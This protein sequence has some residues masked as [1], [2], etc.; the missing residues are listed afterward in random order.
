MIIRILGTNGSGKS[1]V[2]KLVTNELQH[3]Y[4]IKYPEENKR[5]AMGNIWEMKT[6]RRLF[7]P[8]HYNPGVNGGMDTIKILDRAYEKITE[9]HGL[10]CDVLYEGKN[11]ADGSTRALKYH[12]CKIDFR[13]ILMTR[14]LDDC[15]NAV[16]K[17]PSKMAE[18]DIR[19]RY[20]LSIRIAKALEEAGVPVVRTISK[21]A[22]N[23]VLCWLYGLER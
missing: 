8:G 22:A 5:V 1:T 7:I 13:A 18:K 2:V 10:G 6:G 15:I 14:P 11:H 12:Q 20:Y 21:D 4:E 3:I 23:Q 19:Q 16:R 17:R 9:F